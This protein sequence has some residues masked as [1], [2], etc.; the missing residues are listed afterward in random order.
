MAVWPIHT[1]RRR[2]SQENQRE[3]NTKEA[4]KTGNAAHN[5]QPAKHMERSLKYSFICIIAS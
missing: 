4:G 2:V 1:A 3:H 5:V